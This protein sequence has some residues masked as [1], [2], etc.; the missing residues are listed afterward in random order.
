MAKYWILF[1]SLVEI[2]SVGSVLDIYISLICS[3]FTSYVFIILKDSPVPQVERRERDNN[4]R[5]SILLIR[6]YLQNGS[7]RLNQAR[8]NLLE[9]SKWHATLIMS[10]TPQLREFHALSSLKSIPLL[11]IILNP[12]NVSCGYNESRELDLGKLSQLQQI[13]KTSFNESQLQAISVAIGL[14]SSWKK[15][16][17]LSLIQ[18]P[19]GTSYYFWF[20]SLFSFYLL[21]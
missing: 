19:P 9:R 14:S 7:V 15:D 3:L 17:E 11:P 4:R 2:P 10:I 20:F 8:R 21:V 18:G 5:S 1:R 6:F 13:L 12:V 16:C